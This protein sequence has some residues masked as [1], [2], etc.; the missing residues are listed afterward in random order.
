VT[1]AFVRRAVADELT[2]YRRVLEAR[3]TLPS[4]ATALGLRPVR[5]QSTTGSTV[6][7]LVRNGLTAAEPAPSSLPT[8]TS[9]R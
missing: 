5:I 9:L 1:T 6:W 2:G 7:V 8:T 3:A 4:W